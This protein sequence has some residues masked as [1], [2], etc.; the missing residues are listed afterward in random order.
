MAKR[1]DLE[2]AHDHCHHHKAEIERS[3]Y[4]ACFSCFK[5][6]GPDDI[7]DWVDHG[8][9]AVCP[10]CGYDAV[11]GTASGFQLTSQFLRQMSQRWFAEQPQ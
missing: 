4:C 3:D 10:H 5:T 11:L 6:F 8:E 2:K 1:S 9:T 7:A